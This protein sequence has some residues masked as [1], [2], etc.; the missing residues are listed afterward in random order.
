MVRT[1]INRQSLLLSLFLACA[2]SL[3]PNAHAVSCTTQSQ[4]TA[5]QREA[6][7]NTARTAAAQM[8]SGDLQSL[9]AN[10]IP[11]VAAD[12]SDIAA[13]IQNLKPLI[14]QATLTVENL[15]ALDASSE[16]AGS[17]RTDFYCG[18]PLVMLNFTDLPPGTYALAILHA[19]GVP[20]PQQISFILSKTAEN[21]WMLAGFYSRPMI[22]AGHDGLWYWT[23]ARK[24]GQ[25]N[26][27]W[28][29]WFYYRVATYLLNPLD[30]MSSSNLEKLQHEADHIRP[31]ELP[32]TTPMTFNARGA[33]FT[34]TSI[35]T[36]AAFGGLDLDVHYTPDA[37]QATQLH[38]PP[39]ARKQVID[40]M[41]ALLE[42]HPEL[43]SA[44]HGIWVHA[45]QGTASLFALELPMDG[46]TGQSAQNSNP[47]A[48]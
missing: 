4:M 10:T 45:D 41:S 11:A 1:V 25:T 8:Q 32:G 2:V 47:I 39:A 17:H 7:S 44:F 33:V 36:T 19:T 43:H 37:T 40:F 28:D 42:Q 34:V 15:Y 48:R 18:Q 9:R 5:A 35:D 46:I 27:N 22:E 21:R 26:M 31:A 29:A 23:S 16:A 38:D 24:Y 13:L 14:Q 3:L 12:F 6:L 20:Q 30:F